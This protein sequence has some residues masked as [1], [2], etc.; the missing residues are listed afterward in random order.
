MDIERIAAFLQNMNPLITEPRLCS[1]NITPKS[2]CAKCQDICPLQAITLTEKGPKIEQ[3]IS[4]GLCIEACPNHVF[5]LNEKQLLDIDSN[6]TETLILTCPQTFQSIGLGRQKAVTKISCLGELYPELLLY[7]LSTFSRV[8]VF[9]EP[10]VCKKCLDC[11]F[12]EKL[13][14]E[15]F[16]SLLDK[17][18]SERLLVTTNIEKI[19]PYLDNSQIQT[20]HNRRSFFKS[21][22]DSSKNISQRIIDL[23][24]EQDNTT[25][26]NNKE[27]P[28]KIHYLKEALKKQKNLD[29]SK[30]LPYLNLKLNACNFCEAC[31]KLCPTGALKIEQEDTKKKINF[32]P[33]LCT[34]CNICSDVCLYQGLTWENNI[35]LG[36]FLSNEPHFLALPKQRYAKNANTIFMNLILIK[37]M[38]FCRPLQ[39]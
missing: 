27:T 17:N 14:L 30:T 24:L 35:T 15:K 37:T 21:I 13:S 1:K 38:L 12:D 11:S 34:H 39:N 25:K 20:S 4:C 5:K 32:Y 9:Y 28:L 31:C 23:G 22:F 16:S 7:L 10:L 8:I 26:K 19:K 33:S 3:C 18:I 6:Q 2:S 29:Y 36:D